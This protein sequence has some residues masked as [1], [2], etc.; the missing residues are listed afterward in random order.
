MSKHN[1]A[2]L[3][4]AS[5]HKEQHSPSPGLTHPENPSTPELVFLYVF[6]LVR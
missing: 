3:D 5:P 6:P 1:V 2:G 4:Y